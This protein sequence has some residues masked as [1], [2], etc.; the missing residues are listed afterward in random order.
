[1]AGYEELKDVI[2][3]LGLEELS[4]ADRRVVNRARRLERFLTQ[5]FFTTE[6]FTGQSG[7]WS[8]STMCS[9][10]ASAFWPT[11]SST[12]RSRR[13]YMVGGVDEASKGV[14]RKTFC[15]R[16]QTTKGLGNWERA[17]HKMV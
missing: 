17:S 14:M 13:L 1:L 3:M 7:R 4:R 2:A 6:Q 16:S 12:I 5:P 10:A 15:V 8:R 9:T 11:N